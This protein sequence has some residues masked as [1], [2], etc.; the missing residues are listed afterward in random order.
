VITS[1]TFP[2]IRRDQRCRQ[3]HVRK[4]GLPMHPPW[5]CSHPQQR[6][7]E[8][9]ADSESKPTRLSHNSPIAKRTFT[10]LGQRHP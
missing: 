3:P 5:R 7:A 1:M 6:S 2:R 10:I 4:N 8:Y 9:N